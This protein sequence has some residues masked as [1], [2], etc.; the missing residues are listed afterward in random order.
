MV[1]TEIMGCTIA[2]RGLIEHLAKPGVID[3]ASIMHTKADDS[4]SELI[5][6]NQ[7]PLGFEE[8][9]LAPKPINTPEAIPHM[10]DEGD[11]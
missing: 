2:G 8:N 3:I 5:H 1:R 7:D 11:P 9:R 4:A 6:D 10:A